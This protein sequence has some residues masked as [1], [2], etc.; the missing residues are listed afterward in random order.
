MWMLY[1][2]IVL[3]WFINS[4]LGTAMAAS[5]YQ[6]NKD[7]MSVRRWAFLVALGLT[8]VLI[9]LGCGLWVK[10]CKRKERRRVLCQ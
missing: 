3:A 10:W 8:G 2:V 6:K 1:S 4:A 9:P 5:V 7:R